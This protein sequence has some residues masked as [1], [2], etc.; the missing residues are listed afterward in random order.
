MSFG[1]LGSTA[2]EPREEDT[3]LGSIGLGFDGEVSF[4]G[5]V[6]RIVDEGELIVD[7]T[8]GK[9]RLYTGLNYEID[10]DLV[11]VGDCVNGEGTVSSDSSWDNRMPTVSLSEQSFER[12]GSA[13]RNI[14]P[15]GGKP[16]VSFGVS[17]D[18]DVNSCETDVTL[19]HR[20]DEP[21]PADELLVVHRP[22]PRSDTY[23]DETDDVELWWYE[24]DETKN[25][26]DVLEEGE[27]V[28]VTVEGERD[29]VIAWVGEWS[30]EVKGWG[31]SGGVR[32]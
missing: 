3:P 8:T 2:C 7:D 13:G 10:T 9:A 26:E 6:V 23:R 11:G 30:D 31:T 1:C 4:R 5:A 29:G 17:F 15:L 22:D 20:G 16:D 21:V 14:E 12:A 28:T 25:P 24:I 19:T 18:S 27:S 32:C